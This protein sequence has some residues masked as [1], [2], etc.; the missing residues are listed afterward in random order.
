MLGVRISTREIPEI[1]VTPDSF[2]RRSPNKMDAPTI[3]VSGFVGRRIPLVCYSV[4]RCVPYQRIQIATRVQTSDSP[5]GQDI[6]CS[7]TSATQ[8]SLAKKRFATRLR[9]QIPLA[10]MYNAA[11]Q[12][13]SFPLWFGHRERSNDARAT[14]FVVSSILIISAQSETSER[15]NDTTHH[16]FSS[17]RGCELPLRQ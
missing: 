2:G 9:L 10:S 3:V 4:I 1:T 11:L 15:G 14:M 17:G 7:R 6:E 16:N 5:A 8:D 13:L 12:C